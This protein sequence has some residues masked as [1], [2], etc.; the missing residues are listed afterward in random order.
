MIVYPEKTLKIW[1]KTART[2]K[3]LHTYPEEYASKIINLWKFLV[4][5]G[6]LCFPFFPHEND[7]LGIREGPK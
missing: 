4:I 6:E 5:V 1:W 3:R 2:N 7:M